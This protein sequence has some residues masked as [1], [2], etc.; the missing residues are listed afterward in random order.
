MCDV[1]VMAN[2]IVD[3]AANIVNSSTIQRQATTRNPAQYCG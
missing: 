2:D 3:R 1:S